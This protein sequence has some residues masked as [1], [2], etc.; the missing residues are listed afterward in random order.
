MLPAPPRT[1]FIEVTTECNLRC[2]QC[3]MWRSQEP[4]TA[5]STEEKTA[6]L[7]PFATWSPGATV[8]L[9]GGE[10]LHKR[11]ELFALTRACRQRGLLAAANTNATLVDEETVD[12]LLTEGPRFLIVSLDSHR[13]ALHDWIRGVTGTH[14]RAVSMIRRLLTRRRDTYPDSDLRLLTNTIIFDRNVGELEAYVEFARE[15][16]VDGVTFQMLSRTFMR[17]SRGDPFFDRHFPRDVAR[18][19]TAIERLLEL[20]SGGAPIGTTEND[21]RWMKLYARDPDFIGEQ[22]CGSAERNMM[23]DQHGNVQLC[24]F[25]RELLGGRVIGNV[26]QSSLR[27]LWESEFADQARGVMA[28]CRRNCGM[29]NCHRKQE[30]S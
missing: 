23:V 14:D 20:K 5:L 18:V 27:E 22:V 2:Q 4:P 19:D 6:L 11:D 1:L 28:G 30:A 21:L 16:G 9:T 25:M 12:R 7:H 8:V 26:R 15:L 29:L 24:F 3:H 10:P 17:A 13:P